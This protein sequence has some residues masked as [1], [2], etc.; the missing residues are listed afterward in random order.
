MDEKR[1]TRTFYKTKET[2]LASLLST[3]VSHLPLGP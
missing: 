1:R 2:A 3:E